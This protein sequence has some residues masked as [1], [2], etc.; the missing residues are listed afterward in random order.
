MDL[1]Q[2]LHFLVD[3]SP[4][5]APGQLSS[6]LVGPAGRDALLALSPPG[7]IASG[8]ESDSPSRAV[9]PAGQ[10]LALPDVPSVS[11]QDQERCLEGI[12]GIVFVPEHTPTH[13]QHHSA[14]ALHQRGE[15]GL[16][17]PI[18]KLS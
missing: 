4:H 10:R 8:S 15:S 3:D 6:W 9:K 5:L 13:P 12:L 14:I 2:T 11:G 1:G 18:N 17:V 16:I 7:G